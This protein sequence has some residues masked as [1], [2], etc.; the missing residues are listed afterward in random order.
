MSDWTTVFIK[1]LNS[2]SPRAQKMGWLLGLSFVL[3][4]VVPAA[5]DENLSP[6]EKIVH[7]LQI[8][9]PTL[10]L[11]VATATLNVETLLADQ[12]ENPDSHP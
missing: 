10:V 9:V 6:S 11:P 3:L 8:A 2:R 4:G 12:P 7:I 1:L 5:L